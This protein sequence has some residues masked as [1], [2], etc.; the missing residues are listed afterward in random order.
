MMPAPRFMLRLFLFALLPIAL[1]LPALA[2]VS[3]EPSR[4]PLVRQQPSA[5]VT[6]TIEEG[7]FSPDPVSVRAGQTVRWVNRDDRDYSL[8][9]S[10]EAKLKG[11]ASGTIKA[12][13]SWTYRVPG[14][15]SAGSY[16]YACRFRPRA[17]G[18]VRVSG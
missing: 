16:A 1:A 5:D 9:P 11:F 2:F 3:R 18:T 6:V 17:K 15:A 4:T 7:R 10:G 13:S 14:E 12:G 8:A